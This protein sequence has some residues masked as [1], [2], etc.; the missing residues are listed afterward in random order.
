MKEIKAIIEKQN[1]H[2]KASKE[3]RQEY[4]QDKDMSRNDPSKPVFT[5]DYSQNTPISH[6]TKQPGKW[7]YMSLPNLHHFSLDNEGLDTQDNY[8]YTEGKGAKGSNE[9][10]SMLIHALKSL[11]ICNSHLDFWLIIVGTKIIKL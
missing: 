5:F 10:T 2:V 7:Y 4:Q 6:S 8:V 9:E 11:K 1:D 3:L